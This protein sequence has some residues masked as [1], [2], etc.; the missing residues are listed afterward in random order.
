MTFGG[1][2]SS[3]AGRFGPRHTRRWRGFTVATPHRPLLRQT[4][5]CRSMERRYRSLALRLF[6][7]TD[8][9]RVG[10][11]GADKAIDETQ[12]DSDQETGKGVTPGA[13]RDGQEAPTA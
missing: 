13:R 7:G 1:T 11:N 3:P 6:S 4:A 2:R 5:S 9:S 12:G 10:S 8:H